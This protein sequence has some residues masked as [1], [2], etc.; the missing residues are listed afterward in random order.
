MENFVGNSVPA[1]K[2]FLKGG[3]VTEPVTMETLRKFHMLPGEDVILKDAE[4]IVL[5]DSVKEFFNRLDKRKERMEDNK[6]ETGSK[7]LRRIVLK[8]PATND[9]MEGRYTYTGLVDVYAVIEAFSV[10]CPAR[11]HAIKKLLCPGDRGGKD[12][13][14]D[15]VEAKDSIIEAHHMEVGRMVVR[16]KH[17]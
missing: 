9:V 2:M 8:G 15:I 11:A 17:D 6:N 1:V 16:T 4:K 14:Q 5:P 13:L 12:T 10:T 7:Y 3:V